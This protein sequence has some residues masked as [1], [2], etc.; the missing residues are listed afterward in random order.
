MALGKKYT[1]TATPSN[2]WIF[3]GWSVS[4]LP[5][6]VDTASRVLK[7]TLEN[8]V[9]LTANFTPKPF[10]LVKGT[11]CGLFLDSINQ[12]GPANSGWFTFIL[13]EDGTFSGRLL[14]GPANYSFSSKFSE[15][16]TAQVAPNQ[17]VT[18][19][20]QLDMTGKTGQVTGY[21]ND[22]TVPLLGNLT[23]VWTAKNP[24]PYT[25]RYTMVFTNSGSNQVPGGDSYGSLVVS[26]QGVLSVGGKLADGNAFSQSVPI[27]ND[28]LWPF[29][30]YVASGEDFLLGWI[31][32]QYNDLSGA[33]IGE[34]N[35]FWSKGA[36]AKDRY[37]PAGFAG[38]FNLTSSPYVNPGK[39]SPGL[40]LTDPV[41]ILSGGGLAETNPVSYN[42]KLMYSTNDLTLSINPTVGSFTGW[43]KNTGDGPSLKLGGVVLENQNDA[44]GFFLGTNEESGAVLL[45]SQ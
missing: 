30:A 10:T 5:G 44:F 41:V 2:G 6:K 22:P 42:G 40:T 32:F 9:V 4:G 7:F 8:N 3:A 13:S 29:Y 28:G 27:A 37:Y 18:V 39:N 35:F 24:S 1:L 16:G 43:L 25:G 26:P 36:S 33:A 34:T 45:Q 21:V 15:I 20:L 14:M 31:A 11:Y 38:T 12:P 23:P 17:S 19:N